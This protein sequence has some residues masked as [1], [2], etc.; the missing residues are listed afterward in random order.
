MKFFQLDVFTD[1]PY[2]GNPLAVFP[3]AAELSSEQ[4]QSV[5]REMNLSETLFVTAIDDDGYDAR[6]FTPQEEL[7]FAGHPTIGTAWLLAR[8]GAISGAS[9]IQRTAAGP[10]SLELRD[11]MWWFDR[12]GRAERDLDETKPGASAAVAK[13]LGLSDQDI[14]LEARELGRPGHLSP[15]YSYGGLRQL[16]VPVRDVG[17]LGRCRPRS[18][19]LTETAGMGA[20][21]VAAER[22]GYLRA[23]GFWPGVGVDEDP[24]TGSACA[25]LG[26]Y[27]A[28]RLGD[29][30]LQVTQ[31]I[32]MG[33][34]SVM[35]VRA[36]R[37]RVSIGGRCALAFE[38]V[39][40]ALP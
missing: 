15:A 20:Y 31:G 1:A 4:M 21:C 17:V 25:G 24:A 7:P 6:I 13:A 38:G 26:I 33:R 39:L 37:G 11:G 29:I 10:T 28:D 5:A 16:M 9:T 22:P 40:H 36:S 35:R 2:A 23:R 30:D 8:S 27:L 19:L 32:E 3:D 12:E 34:P 18:D 14:G